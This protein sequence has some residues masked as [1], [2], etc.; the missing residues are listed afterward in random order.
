[1]SRKE[2]SKHSCI[3][4]GQVFGNASLSSILICLMI[5]NYVQ[6]VYLNY[7]EQNAEKYVQSIK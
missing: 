1:M 4:L 6:K 7:L 2:N 3:L 5:N